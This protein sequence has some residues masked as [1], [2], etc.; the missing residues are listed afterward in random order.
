MDFTPGT[1]ATIQA[2]T[3]ENQFFTL[4]S[5]IQSIELDGQKNEKGVNIV[6][7]TIDTDTNILTGSAA[8]HCMINRN[9]DTGVLSFNYP[10]SFTGI[11]YSEGTGGESKASGTITEALVER[12]LLIINAE[13][14]KKRTESVFILKFTTP[15]WSYLDVPLNAPVA[16]NAMFKFGF[17]LPTVTTFTGNGESRSAVEYL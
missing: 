8:I 4:C 13:R 1:G 15:A 6:S 3:L 10:S 11:T 12:A 7:Y 16:H 17:N 14:Q 2:N 9:A 5:L